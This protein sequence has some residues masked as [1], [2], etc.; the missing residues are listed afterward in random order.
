MSKHELEKLLK[1]AEH[2]KGSLVSMSKQIHTSL[3]GQI[4]TKC[5]LL[6]KDEK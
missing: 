1:K 4:I 3:K 6:A 5:E 2:K